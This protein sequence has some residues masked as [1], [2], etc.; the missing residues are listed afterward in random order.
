M[1]SHERQS[2][3]NNNDQKSMTVLLYY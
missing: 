3:N 2:R 1:D